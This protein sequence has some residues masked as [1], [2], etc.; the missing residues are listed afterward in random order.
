M[1]L[2]QSACP[3]DCF[4][5]C[6]FHV[7]RDES[8]EIIV[9]GDPSD[10]V[11]QGF[12]CPKGQRVMERFSHPDRITSPLKKVNGEFLPVSW[13][14]AMGEIAERMA[15]ILSSSGPHRIIHYHDSGHGGLSKNISTAFFNALGGVTTPA[16]SLCWGAGTAAQV[17]DFGHVYGHSPEDLL[18][19]RCLILWGRNPVETNRHMMPF[20]RQLKEKGVPVFLVDPVKTASARWADVHLALRPGSDGHLAL[21]MAKHLAENGLINQEYLDASTH[22]GRSFVAA[23][24]SFSF[25]SLV[26]ATGLQENQVVHLAETYASG[27]PGCIYLGYGMQRNSYGARNVRLV[28][29]LGALCGHIGK[30]GGGV[31]YAHRHIGQYIDRAFLLHPPAT[32][33]PTFPQPRFAQEI[34]RHPSGHYQALFVTQAN[35]VVQLPDTRQTLA[36][37]QQIPLKV[38]V[39]HFLTDTA[40]Q[41]DYVL[42]PTMI[43]EESDVVFSSMWHARLSWT[44]QVVTPPS[45]VRHEFQIFQD[46]AQRLSLRTFLDRYP[47]VSSYLEG[48]VHPLTHLLNCTV[49][50]LKGRRLAVPGNEVPWKDGIFHTPSGK[51]QFHIPDASA[52]LPLPGGPDPQ[53]PY[54]LLTVHADESLHSQHWRTLPGHE[55]PQVQVNPEGLEAALPPE[56]NPVWLVSR[57]GRLKCSVRYNESLQ[58]GVLVMKQGTWLKNGSVNQLTPQTLSDEGMQAAYYD[59]RCQILPF[60]ESDAPESAPTV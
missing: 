14:Q 36:A 44:E 35:P 20:I 12:L 2:F 23:L 24:E 53:Y 27:D 45:D 48:A 41:A 3:L 7:S 5:A 51:F 29:A 54:H 21:A 57:Q 11:T 55:L 60:S 31:N 59:C 26:K 10:P 52:D 49:D 50:D 32:P 46:L 13:D 1:K 42:P 17:A 39:D 58:T 15:S 38:V 30:P 6:S 40:S 8:N 34:L 43:L 16:G 4:D 19:T 18:N 56:G 25:A 33:A 28:D 9:S 37:F 47:S 22:N